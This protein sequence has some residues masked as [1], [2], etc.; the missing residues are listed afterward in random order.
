MN[1]CWFT[2]ENVILIQV[3]VE[4]NAWETLWDWGEPGSGQTEGGA[5]VCTPPPTPPSRRPVAAPG[6]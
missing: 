3:M 1:R 4:K 5:V 2:M 6:T